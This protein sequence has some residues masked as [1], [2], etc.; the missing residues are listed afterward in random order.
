MDNAKAIRRAMMIAQGMADGGT[1]DDDYR[2]SHQA[3]SPEFG[4]PMHDVTRG[5]YPNDFYSSKGAHY[6]GGGLD[7]DNK[8]HSQILRAKDKP[9]QSVKIYRAVPY[10]PSNKE[11][12]DELN[13]HKAYV[14]KTGKLPKNVTGNWNNPSSYYN[15]ANDEINRLSSLPESNQSPKK[16]N[17]GDWVAITPE[18]ARE[19]G[20]QALNGK[21]KVLTK[22][23]R[24]KDLWTNGDSFHEWGYHPS[25][26]K[27]RGGF[28]SDPGKE[29]TELKNHNIEKSLGG[30][31]DQDKAIR[32]A[33]MIARSMYASGGSALEDDDDYEE[34]GSAPSRELE[35][36]VQETSNPKR[37][38]VNAKG[39]GGVKGI[40]VPRHMLEGN[41]GVFSKGKKAGQSFKNAGMRDINEARAR[42]YGSENRDPLTIGQIGRIHKETIQGHF[43]KSLKE[44]KKDEEAALRR[45]Q[46]AQHIKKG[47][48]TLDKSEKTDTVKFENDPYVP[49]TSKGIAGHAL[50]TSGI[51]ENQVRHV[52]NT[53]PGQT[54]GCGGGVDENGIVDTSNGTCF[55]PNAE[56]QYVSAAIRRACHEQAKHDPAMTRDWILAHIGSLRKASENNDK[57]GQKTLFRPNVVDETD[58][59]SRHVIKALNAQRLA[60]GL[61]MIIAN[62]YGKTNE[63]HDPENGYY[64]TYSNIGPKTKL[65]SSIRENIG[66]DNK[67][68]RQTITGTDARGNDIV[69]ED[70]HVTPV[71]NSYMVND[72]KRYSDLDKKIQNSITHA[73]YW[74]APRIPTAQ[75][76]A[77]GDEGHFDGDGNPTTPDQAHYGHTTLN[78]MR[79]DYQKQ[80]IIHPR[81]VAVGQNS[82][83][84][85]K[86]IPTDS[87]F[88]DDDYLPPEDQRFK[89]KNGK[90]AG[91][92]LMT[93]PT[94]STSNIGHQT[95]FTHHVDDSHVNH[96]LNNN[97]EYEIDSPA[98]QMAS[99]GKE[100]VPPKEIKFNRNPRSGFAHG[101]TVGLGPDDFSCGLPEQNYAAQM[102]HAHK[103]DEEDHILH[104]Q[105]H[106]DL[107]DNNV[108]NRAL[109]MVG[110]MRRS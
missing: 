88:R 61:S 43:S 48:N 34:E 80:H 16:I 9:N 92:I 110:K 35:S 62:S 24:A 11:K 60:K 84:S 72:V 63:L 18:Y 23:V 50:Y 41:E 106:G 5:I 29:I 82:D 67:R 109:S 65:G 78:G 66:L 32:S 42:V 68:V 102:H 83:G 31:M 25:E 8:T 73:K 7:Y 81:M 98:A 13:F 3:P 57:K 2:G 89:T 70:G 15:W 69:N 85:P 36:D 99:A 33:M 87:R 53:C 108:V 100:Y 47:A 21:Y 46:D 94:E 93:T 91:A 105:Y 37:V 40:I 14:M 45:L 54:V 71:K 96:A 75:D 1:P 74:S 10:E 59:S 27:A 86:Y 12:I 97:G 79:F 30:I 52:I 39:P 49:F 95:S 107:S 20:E 19:H 26:E 38:L 90:L 17:N 104:P 22:T 64:V 58:V 28:I 103:R 4:A 76:K 101:G 6:Y 56:S 55:A 77:E 51:G 44:Q